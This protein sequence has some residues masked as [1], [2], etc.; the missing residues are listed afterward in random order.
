MLNFQIHTDPEWGTHRPSLS[1]S[2]THPEWGTHRPFTLLGSD[3][4]CHIATRREARC[5]LRRKDHIASR[6]SMMVED[7]AVCD[8]AASGPAFFFALALAFPRAN[9][10][11]FAG[12][13]LGTSLCSTIHLP[14]DLAAAFFNSCAQVGCVVAKPLV[15]T[16]CCGR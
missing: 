10:S 9:A 16:T 7:T 12:V 15:T 11:L 13:S 14:A 4:R 8:A 6:E 3:A 2:H 5:I 1:E